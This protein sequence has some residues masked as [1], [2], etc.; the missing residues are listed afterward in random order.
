MEQKSDYDTK[1]VNLPRKN[2]TVYKTARKFQN[3]ENAPKMSYVPKTANY[4]SAMINKTLEEYKKYIDDP[5]IERKLHESI[6]DFCKSQ[7][8]AKIKEKTRNLTVELEQKV[9]DYYQELSEPLPKCPV[10]LESNILCPKELKCKHELC[11]MCYVKL[12]KTRDGRSV[13][14]KCPVC[15]KHDHWKLTTDYHDNS[16]DEGSSSD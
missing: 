8:K 7:K 12:I 11:Y 6:K 16:D 13:C 2:A 10:C 1:K 4:Q 14:V 9:E 5:A 15:R 3:S